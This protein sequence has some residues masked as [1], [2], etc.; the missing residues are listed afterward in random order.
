MQTEIEAPGP[1]GP[2]K[3]TLLSPDTADVP[4]VLIVPGSGATDRNGNAP[5]WLQASTYRLLAEGLCE[6]SIASVR[7][8]KRGMYGSASAIP[9]AN[10]VTI[11]DYA[12]DIHAWVAAIRARTGA[13]SVWV[14]GHSEG[15]LVALLAAR[16]SADIAGLILVATPGRPLGPVLRQQLRSNPANAPF[17][18]NAMSIL[19]SLEAG[20]RVDAARIDPVLMQLFR[21][22]VQRF[23]MSELTV[24]P[25]ALLADYMKPVLIVQGA[26]DIQVG[27]Q[28]AELLK[29]AN[30]RAEMALIADANHVLK[31]VGTVDR[32]ENLAAYSNPDLPLAKGVVTAISAF[33]QASTASQ[34]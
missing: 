28:D 13:S 10:D 18:E 33:V 29:H 14:L 1:A 22:Q 17:L 3:G 34:R 4:V 31:T 20:D 27:V 15:G 16:Q 6:E 32:Q 2:L 30:P 5:S 8:D 25:A 26:R 11:E 12:A 9:D 7:I 19:D 24:D 23:L 21:P